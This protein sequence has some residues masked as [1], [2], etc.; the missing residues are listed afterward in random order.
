MSLSTC[1]CLLSSDYDECVANTS[2]CN[3]LCTNTL[4]SYNCSCYSG[5]QLQNATYC[6]DLD[7]CA[8]N[9]HDCHSL[10][11]CTNT[12]GKFNCSC[13]N[14]FTGNGTYCQ[15][16][17]L[18]HCGFLIFSGGILH[19][20]GTR[21]AQTRF[22]VQRRFLLEIQC[23]GCSYTSYF[24]QSTENGL[25]TALINFQ[26]KLIHLKLMSLKTS[27]TVEAKVDNKL[28]KGSREVRPLGK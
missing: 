4:G 9:Q 23:T 15:G 14:G 24:L 12:P 2:Q 11:T 17:V 3:Q 20:K 27:L 7:E 1:N 21:L 16:K 18:L 8:T 22:L 5:Y 26:I 6:G 13:N 10:A 25:Q 28:N 19:R